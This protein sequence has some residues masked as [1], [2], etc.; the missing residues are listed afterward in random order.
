M[1]LAFRI[2]RFLLIGIGCLMIVGQ[3]RAATL[4]ASYDAD[5]YYF[6]QTYRAVRTG[7]DLGTL[8]VGQHILDVGSTYYRHFN[9][10]AITFDLSSMAATGQ[11]FLSLN[12]KDFK[13]PV[14]LFPGGPP[15]YSFLSSGN[16]QLAIVALKADFREI[17]NLTDLSEIEAWYQDN[18]FSQPRIV[19]V[20][21]TTA[22]AF[23][24]DVTSVVDGWITNSTPNF[25]FGLIGLDSTPTAST[26]RFY[27]ME[28]GGVFGPALIPE[29]TTGSLA[30][31]GL[32]GV[33]TMRW[34]FLVKN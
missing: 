24:V 4:G 34:R 18:L 16:F 28:A 30:L 6:T 8:H 27:S 9:Y 14:S 2:M 23:Q 22:G 19:T 33:L 10:G 29:P 26:L 7:A 12:V 31:L 15:S 17:E 25:G 5:V 21:L 13:T 11:K 1:C 3:A 20:N 32:A